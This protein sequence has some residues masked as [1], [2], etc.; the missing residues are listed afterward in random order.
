MPF[1]A[2]LAG[3]VVN[4]M[5]TAPA[6]FSDLTSSYCDSRRIYV[7]DA[8][9]E[10]ADLRVIRIVRTMAPQSII[11]A[12]PKISDGFHLHHEAGMYRPAHYR[13]H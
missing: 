6:L 1:P 10:A 13:A 11:E 8:L 4:G 5:V 7:F 2:T 12:I 9:L 3:A